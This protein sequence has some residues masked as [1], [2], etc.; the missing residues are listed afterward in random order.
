MIQLKSRLSAVSPKIESRFMSENGITNQK[1]DLKSLTYDE[2]EAFVT[3][4]GEK[5]FRAGQ[6]FSWLH[7][8]RVTSFNEATSLSKEFRMRL[9]KEATLA[10]LKVRK[11]QTSAIDGTKKYLFECDD[12][13]LIESVFM[14]YS[15]G[16]SVCI[17]SQVGCA[18]GCKFCAS[19]VDGVKRNLTAGEM[20]EQIHAICRESQE[21]VS[22]VVVMGSGEPFLNYDNLKRF[23]YILSDERGM[24]IGRRHITVS[25][26][27]IVPRLYDA[28]KDF[29]QVNMA[30][31]LHAAI[32]SKREAIMPTAKTYHLDDIFD[33]CKKTAEQTGRRLT[34]EYALM[35]GVNDTRED[36][37]ALHDRLKDLPCVLNLIRVNPVREGKFIEPNGTNVLFFQKNLE[38]MGIN[39]T[40]RREMGRDI[41]GACG[42]LARRYTV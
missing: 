1:R 3:S 27:G 18:C 16:N 14:P 13:S 31:S 39:V 38:K 4:L 21:E 29:P 25:T 19:T 15:F 32:Q 20:L 34:F 2:L 5:R 42:Q 12:G 10:V 11:V 9:E 7:D 37:E 30:V 41:D 26:C 24:H 40:I 36:L 23:I 28:A 33:A 8:K 17:S 35:Q 22:R 6:L